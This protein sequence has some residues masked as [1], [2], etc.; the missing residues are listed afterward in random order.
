MV[1]GVRPAA[2]AHQPHARRALD[3]M[4]L[5]TAMTTL[6][7]TEQPHPGSHGLPC[8]GTLS[9]RLQPR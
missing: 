7:M 4:C 8:G 2:W 9:R 5:M 6:L 3:G 1:P